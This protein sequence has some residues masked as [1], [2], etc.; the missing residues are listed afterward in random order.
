MSI[1]MSAPSLQADEPCDHFMVGL[2]F[3]HPPVFDKDAS[4]VHEYIKSMQR[5]GAVMSPTQSGAVTHVILSKTGPPGSEDHD[6]Y[7]VAERSGTRVVSWFWIEQSLRAKELVSVDDSALFKPPP[8]LDGL[9]EFR[10]VKVCVTG[11]TGDRRNELITIVGLLGAE[12]MRSLDRRSTHLVCFEFEGAKWAKANQTG[13]QKIVSHRW[14]EQCLRRHSKLSEAP[15]SERSG[16]EEDELAA[17]ALEDPEIPDSDD[18]NEQNVIEDSLVTEEADPAGGSE[19]RQNESFITELTAGAAATVALN[20]PAVIT[21]IAPGTVLRDI[22]SA[23]KEDLVTLTGMEP[24]AP[25]PRAT[26]E[27]FEQRNEPD[28]L[29]SPDWSALELRASQHIERS[30]RDDE[31]DP[32]LGE[33]EGRGEQP[34]ESQRM[35]AGRVG[36]PNAVEAAFGGRFADRQPQRFHK[37]NDADDPSAHDDFEVFLTHIADGEWDPAMDVESECGNRKWAARL[38]NDQTLFE[39]LQSRPEPI[40]GIKVVE[41]KTKGHFIAFYDV[42]QPAEL[43]DSWIELLRDTRVKSVRGPFG[44]ATLSKLKLEQAKQVDKSSF[45]GPDALLATFLEMYCPFGHEMGWKHLRAMLREVPGDPKW[46][47]E[48]GKLKLRDVNDVVTL[49]ARTPGNLKGV[50]LK[51]V[52]RPL[53]EVLVGFHELLA[54]PTEPDLTQQMTQG[55]PPQIT[56]PPSSKHWSTEQGGRMSIQACV[57]ELQA[58]VAAAAEGWLGATEDE[59]DEEDEVEEEEILEK[60]T[61]ED[62]RNDLA[63]RLDTCAGDMSLIEVGED[64]D[65]AMGNQSDEES[66]LSDDNDDDVLVPGRGRGRKKKNVLLTQEESD[67]D[68]QGDEEP[69][70][71]K[72]EEPENEEPEIVPEAPKESVP[73]AKRTVRVCG[74]KT[75]VAKQTPVPTK[76]KMPASTRHT[77]NT[78]RGAKS[79]S[80]VAPPET[81]TNS[82]KRPRRDVAKQSE[83]TQRTIADEKVAKTKTPTS[84]NATVVSKTPK[85]KTPVASKAK[86]PVAP[87]TKTPTVASKTPKTATVPKVS[88]TKTPTVASKTKT[89]KKT[90][91][92]SS[93]AKTPLVDKR[94]R[95]ALSGFSS[96]DLTKYG[97]TVTKLG[98]SLC[99]G[100]GWD[101][102]ATHVVFGPRGSRS[103]KFLA[104]AAAGVPLLD[105]SYLDACRVAGK[106]LGPETFTGHLWKG[107]WRGTDAGLVSKDASK[108]WHVLMYNTPFT[109]LAVGVAPFPSANRVERDMLVS[110]LRA[111]GAKVST[112]SAKGV[113][114]PST[115]AP[116]VVIVDPGSASQGEDLAGRAAVAAQA[117]AGGACV[118]PEFFKS[119]LSRPGS[120]LSQY[121]LRGVVVGAL[122]DAL[123]RT[124]SKGFGGPGSGA[125]DGGVVDGGAADQDEETDEEEEEAPKTAKRARTAVSKSTPKS[126]KISILKPKPLS[127]SAGVGAKD[128][129]ASKTPSSG[130]KRT[131]AKDRPVQIMGKRRRV[132][133]TRN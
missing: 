13:I 110:V 29:L 1:P 12:Y 102:R 42:S 66:D 27:D 46:G 43:V 80:P 35:F 28:S 92:S 6:V 19:K 8:S 71:E 104:G 86:T 34:K 11:Y 58:A 44:V 89:T 40:P 127:A 63:A 120:D 56:A 132:L 4:T 85:T 31:L 73:S 53:R 97:A 87:K 129:A 2:V 96:A 24:P 41:T 91:A 67:G 103:I 93:V 109:D 84:K 115:P 112:I 17:Q 21:G 82:N 124:G 95:V 62:V 74:A 51:E 68:E 78:P 70:D 90:D 59:Q 83:Q 26:Q 49:P 77:R 88:K 14:L 25:R 69:E 111:G 81:L 39:V 117:A 133:G 61:E 16:K 52:R 7:R 108:I 60:N 114:I 121:V 113:L 75:P 64:E 9:P 131:P 57:P 36:S 55:K 116:D 32:L 130:N 47:T 50:E 126:G 10:N 118:S 38:L 18:E 5:A 45:A 125:G 30:R 3:Y 20:D 33:L 22:S 107:G 119:W 98:A 76:E 15:Y 79:A 128:A 54:G 72:P 23:P 37:F 101:T 100:H 65:D 99:A 123:T 105:K 106:L 48:S 94:P 122:L